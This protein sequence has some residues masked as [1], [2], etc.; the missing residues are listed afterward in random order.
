[1]D[2]NSA[3]E[4]LN[5]LAQGTR[6]TVFRRLVRAGP[7]GLCPSALQREL[8]VSPS[9]LSFHLKALRSAGLAKVRQSGRQWFYS[10]DFDAM[11]RLIGFLME[12]C[13]EQSR[14]TLT[15]CVEPPSCASS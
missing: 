15:P 8:G 4:C 3:V 1:M 14:T 10:A 7:E 5:A 9:A 13:C 6:L 12:N 2:T 11:Q